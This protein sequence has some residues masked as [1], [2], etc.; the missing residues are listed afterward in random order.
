MLC[1]FCDKKSKKIWKGRVS[2]KRSYLENVNW[3]LCLTHFQIVLFENIR[4]QFDDM[5]DLILP[6]FRNLPPY[7]PQD[8]RFSCIIPTCNISCFKKE[9]L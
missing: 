5:T 2:L 1:Q 4:N 6:S 7:I 9:I 3:N 8:T